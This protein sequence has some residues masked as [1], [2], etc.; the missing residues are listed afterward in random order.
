[1]AIRN[2]HYIP[3]IAT[4][5]IGGQLTFRLRWRL[6]WRQQSMR[7]GKLESI[8]CRAGKNAILAIE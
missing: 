3:L 8:N 1:M 5:A 4:P 2:A 6:H 7:A